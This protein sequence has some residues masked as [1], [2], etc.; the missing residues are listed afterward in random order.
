MNIILLN[1]ILLAVLII[2]YSQFKFKFEKRTIAVLFLVVSLINYLNYRIEEKFLIDYMPSYYKDIQY[3]D[4]TGFTGPVGK[5]FAGSIGYTGGVPDNYNSK[6][7]CNQY[8]SYTG[9]SNLQT[10]ITSLFCTY[11]LFALQSYANLL[12]K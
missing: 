11:S 5:G 1:I 10:N 4:Y 12:S 6:I 8:N 3:A 2:I 9:C 7:F